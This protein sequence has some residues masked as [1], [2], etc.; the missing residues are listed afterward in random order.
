MTGSKQRLGQWGEDLAALEYERL[1]LRLVDRNWRVNEGEI[2]IIAAVDSTS[3]IVFCEVKTRSSDRF[4]TGAESVTVAKQRQ[5][6]KVAL[7]WLGQCGSRFDN[8]RFDVASVNG[9][10]DV[11]LI[12]DCF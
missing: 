3:T 4:G 10:G 7:L 11:E 1:G 6:R 9:A 5:V 2:D 8:I 12:E